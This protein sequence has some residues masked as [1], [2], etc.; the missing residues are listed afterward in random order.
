MTNSHDQSD[1]MIADDLV[2]EL[3]AADPHDAPIIAEA[4][5]EHLAKELRSTEVDAA[6]EQG[7]GS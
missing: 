3:S 2:E 4:L 5:A 1:R 6:N 7:T